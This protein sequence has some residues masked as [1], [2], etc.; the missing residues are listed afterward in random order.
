MITCLGF[1]SRHESIRR[2]SSPRAQ[3]R[4]FRFCQWLKSTM[5]PR[6]DTKL[7]IG[8]ARLTVTLMSRRYSQSAYSIRVL[9]DFVAADV[10]R[11]RE[12][13]QAGVLF[14]QTRIFTRKSSALELFIG[15]V[16]INYSTLRKIEKETPYRHD[17]NPSPIYLYLLLF[18]SGHDRSG[19]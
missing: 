18:I 16:S 10:V 5:V 17:I 14:V 15:R 9:C 11:S 4:R 19:R 3:F 13:A 8:E 6:Y 12:E 7:Q 1:P 2:R